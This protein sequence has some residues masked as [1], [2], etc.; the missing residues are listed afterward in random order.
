K[1]LQSINL[2]IKEGIE[3][4][5]ASFM[6]SAEYVNKVRQATE[7]KMKIISKI[8]CIDALDNLDE[9]IEASDFLLLDRGDLSKEIPIEKIPLTQKIVLARARRAGKGV[10]VATNLLETMVEHKKPTRAEVNDVISTIIDG[11]YGLTLSAETAIGKYPIECINM[12]NRLIKQAELARESGDFNKKEDQVVK[13][14]EDINYL[15]NINLSSDLIEPHGGKLVNRILSGEPDRVYLSSLPKITLNENLQMDVEQIAIGTFSPIEGFMNQDDFAG[16]LNNM[17]L[18]SGEVWTIPIILDMSEEQAEGI[19][20]GND[21]A[22]TDQSGEPVAILHVED[23]YY[24]DKNDTCLKLY[25]TADVA[26][27]GVR[28]IYGLQSVLLGGKI[29]LIKRRTTEYKEYELTPR[30]VRK[31]FV[32]RGWSKITGFHTRNVIHRSHEF[33]QLETMRRYHCDGLFIHPVIGKKKLGD[34]QAKFIIKGYEKMMKDFYPPDRVVLAAF[35]TFSRYAGPREAV[36]TALCRK[37]FG[38]SHFIVGR[39]HTGVGDFYHPKAS[40]EIF[41]QLPDLGIRP[42]KFDKVFFSQKQNR[43]IHESESPEVPEEDK[44]HIS[45]TQAREILEKGEYPPEWFM[46]PEIAKIIID[47]VNNNEEVFVK[48]ETKNK[49]KIIWFTGLSG[50]GKTTIA[51]GLKKKLEF[52]NKSVKIID[53][54]DVRSD[55]HKHLGFSREDVKE[56]NRL[57]AELAKEEAE[58]FDFVLVPIISPYQDDRKMVREINGENFIELFIDAPLE[59]CVKRDVKGLYKKALAGEI[60]DF[61]GLSETSPYEVP[62]NPDIRLKTNELSIADGVDAIV[63]YLKITNTL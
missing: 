38:C 14:L 33:I 9:I 1:D 8:E 57:V 48:G 32:E 40:H 62:Q 13:K 26:H 58:K 42:V 12:M 49:G 44:L 18:A 47:A 15:L 37:N 63:N 39:D 17:R 60:D 11:A 35:S 10:F 46:R 59:V 45:G 6:R 43:H 51:L 21:V 16:V 36:F 7:G 52:L 56:N 50:S 22:L 5:A 54:D 28:W 20:V 23:K 31:L 34:F 41:D 30:Q 24:F 29:S 2:G 53:G 25:G 19:A 3:Y 61:I 4:I 27:P 55:Q